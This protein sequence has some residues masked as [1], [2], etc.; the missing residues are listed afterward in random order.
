MLHI[1]KEQA[2]NKIIDRIRGRQIQL[3]KQSPPRKHSAV[4]INWILEGLGRKNSNKD[5]RR[6]ENLQKKTAKNYNKYWT[7]HRLGKAF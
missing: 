2:T 6:C 7:N 1:E 5:Q 3:Q 4:D